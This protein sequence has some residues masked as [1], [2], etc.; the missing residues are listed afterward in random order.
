MTQTELDRA[1]AN[2]TGESPRIISHL[3]FTIA[4][5]AVVDFDPEPDDT[6]PQYLDWEQMQDEQSRSCPW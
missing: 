3:G 6:P 2:A 5:P 1:V 4:D